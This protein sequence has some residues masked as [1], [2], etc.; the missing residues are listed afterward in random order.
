MDRD[1]INV[2]FG[3][4]S[5]PIFYLHNSFLFVDILR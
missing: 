2:A 4:G 5:P 3:S 1:L